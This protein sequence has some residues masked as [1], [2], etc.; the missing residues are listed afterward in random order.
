MK[1]CKEG[2][3]TVIF[4]WRTGRRGGCKAFDI[5]GEARNGVVHVCMCMCVK[6]NQDR[7]CADD[8]QS[9][10]RRSMKFCEAFLLKEESCCARTILLCNRASVWLAEV[11]VASPRGQ[12]NSKSEC[13]REGRGTHSPLQLQATF[14]RMPTKRHKQDEGVGKGECS[15]HAQASSL[16]TQEKEELN[17]KH[18]K[19]NSERARAK[20]VMRE[21][22]VGEGSK[23]P[24]GLLWLDACLLFFW[25]LYW[26]FTRSGS[27]HRQRTL[28]SARHGCGARAARPWA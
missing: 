14:H 12:R 9:K 16:H 18:E 25:V 28:R 27:G 11:P 1:I 20:W 4:A 19:K 2:R 6:T 10:K 15:F 17:N 22:G 5:Q 21:C 23:D 24:W 3:R 8:T 26:E 13:S 7:L